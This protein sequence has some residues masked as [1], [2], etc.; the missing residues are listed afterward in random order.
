MTGPLPGVAVAGLALVAALLTALAPGRIGGPAPAPPPDGTRTASGSPPTQS[1]S[2]S[3]P[4]PCLPSLR[5]AAAAAR[6][7]VPSGEVGLVV[8]DRATGVVWSAGAP[9][10]RI[11]AGSTPKLALAVALLEQARAG[12]INLDGPAPTRPRVLRR[13]L[14]RHV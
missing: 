14:R 6:L 9:E 7:P 3:C 8:L 2:A 1:R 13:R 10:T 12:T 4:D 5:F 11:W